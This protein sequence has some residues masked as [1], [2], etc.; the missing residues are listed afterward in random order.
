MDYIE[1]NIRAFLAAAQCEYD[2]EEI[3]AILYYDAQVVMDVM[4]AAGMTDRRF[5]ERRIEPQF[6]VPLDRRAKDRRI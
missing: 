4:Y 1:S 2:P 6:I 5:R 3:A